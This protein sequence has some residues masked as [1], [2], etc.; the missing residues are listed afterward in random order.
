VLAVVVA[1]L[2]STPSFASSQESRQLASLSAEEAVRWA[3]Q[4]RPVVAAAQSEVAALETRAQAVRSSAPLRLLFGR[5]NDEV[6]GSTDNDLA[7]SQSID[8]FGRSRLAGAVA[9]SEANIARANLRQVKLE[10][11]SEVLNLFNQAVVSGEKLVIARELVAIATRFRDAA[12]RRVDTGQ[13]P[14]V[15]LL[16]ANIELE[17]ATQ[18]LELRGSEA[19]AAISRLA[20]A[21]GAPNASPAGFFARAGS[22]EPSFMQRVPRVLALTAELQLLN[23]RIRQ[24]KISNRPDVELQVRRSPWMDNAQVGLR[25][26]VSVPITDYGRSRRS[27]EALQMSRRGFE[28]Q[29]EDALRMAAAEFQALQ[30]ERN[31]AERQ[32]SKL[33][34]LIRDAE[35]L[36]RINERGFET[37][38]LTLIE[39]LEAARSLREIEEAL[40]D[41]K[42]RLATL[43]VAILKTEGLLLEEG[44]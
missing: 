3:I 12:K 1:S 38:A 44:A 6:P 9:D 40:L 28:Q 39:S 10:V 30:Q 31:G 8:W 21:T 18:V 11:Q 7:L 41:A 33:E 29:R 15:Q 2:V 27:V 36:L 34:A 22:P 23:D 16:R 32:V 4:N 19:L 14:E 20:G 43:D 13:A 37:G 25:V 35:E 17:R 5:G 24:E 42:F 26:Q